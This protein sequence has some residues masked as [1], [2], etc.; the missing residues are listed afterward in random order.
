MPLIER[1]YCRSSPFVCRTGRISKMLDPVMPLNYR[2]TFAMMMNSASSTRKAGEFRAA[3]LTGVNETNCS[4]LM[5][6]RL[7]HPQGAFKLSCQ[8][9]GACTPLF[10]LAAASPRRIGAR[11]E[12]YQKGRWFGTLQKKIVLLDH[13]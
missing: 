6:L 8:C 3:G 9:A 13:C 1:R 12:F 7:L 10:C 11:L 4:E 2:Q 5:K